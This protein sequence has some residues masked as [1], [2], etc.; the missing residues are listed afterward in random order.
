[1]DTVPYTSYIS[2]N[3]HINVMNVKNI[4]GVVPPSF[5]N[6]TPVNYELYISNF[7]KLL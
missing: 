7:Q 4:D 2:I 1:M 3:E 6:Y 5:L